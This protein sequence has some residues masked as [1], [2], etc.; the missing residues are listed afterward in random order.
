MKRISAIQF[1]RVFSICL[2]FLSHCSELVVINGQNVLSKWGGAG[3]SIFIAISGFLSAYNYLNKENAFNSWILYKQKWR[4]YGP[5]HFVT[6]I[7]SIPLMIS[8][9]RTDV[10]K[11]FIALIC[12]GFLIQAF[13]PV[14][15]IYFSYNAVSWYLSLTIFFVVMIPICVQLWIRMNAKS[16]LLSLIAVWGGSCSYVL[17]QKEVRYSIG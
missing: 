11:S 17:L 6:L 13:V 4:K 12:N 8:L 16:W 14:E 3:V 15:S 9:I 2:I 1:L 5:T 7:I 10:F